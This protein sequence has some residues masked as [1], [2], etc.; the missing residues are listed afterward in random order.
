MKTWLKVTL[1][2]VYLS[3]WIMS[4]AYLIQTTTNFLRTRQQTLGQAF[5]SGWV[6]YKAKSSKAQLLLALGFALLLIATVTFTSVAAMV[7]RSNREA[8]ITSTATSQVGMTTLGET[9]TPVQNLALT[10]PAITAPT[11]A[12]TPA[13][14]WKPSPRPT[15]RPTPKPTQK[16]TPSP[17]LFITFTCAVAVDYSYGRVCVHTLPGAALTITVTYCSGYDA[18][19][20]SLQGMSYAD[21]SGDQAWTWTPETKCRGTATAVVDA[22]WQGQYTSNSDGFTVQ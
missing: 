10:T 19:S 15:A 9:S 3:M 7:D 20:R 1:I 21:G 6:W 18:V 22:S 17:Q 11:V 16:P 2:F 5:R 4:G 13:P 14:T 12:P 8:Q